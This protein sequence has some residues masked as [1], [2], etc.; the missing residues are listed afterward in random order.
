MRGK[1][2][3]AKPIVTVDLKQSANN[4]IIQKKTQEVNKR[5][6][7]VTKRAR[8]LFK[9]NLHF[10][11]K[12]KFPHQANTHLP[13]LKDSESVRLPNSDE[14]DSARHLALSYALTQQHAL[15]AS[16]TWQN[17]A[18]ISQDN[19]HSQYHS[20]PVINIPKRWKDTLRPMDLAR[21]NL[22]KKQ[23]QFQE[24]IYEI[25][26]TEQSYLDDLILTYKV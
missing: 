24:L 23:I 1:N 7:T 9:K 5:K 10:F 25:I 20:P 21:Y 11:M 4:N 19:Q 2:N 17:L 13:L 6:S 3:T 12:G 8:E 22:D 16:A 15:H 14:E 26:L 18:S